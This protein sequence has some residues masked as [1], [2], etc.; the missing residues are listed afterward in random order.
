MR[1]ILNWLGRIV[2][3]LLLVAMFWYVYNAVPIIT[4]YS[5]KVACSCLFISGRTLADVK[6]TE[7]N[8][9][10]FSLANVTIN[11][12]DSSITAN[13][14]GM[15][16]T[17]AVYRSGLGCTLTHYTKK[18][19]L[20]AQ[21][22]ALA[23]PLQIDQDT[24][25]WPMG[26]RHSIDTLNANANLKMQQAASY[27]FQKNKHEYTFG[28]RALLVVKAGKIV[29]EQYAA[30]FSARTRMAGWSM[31]K[32]ITNAMVGILVKQGKLSISQANLFAGWKND[33]RAG[34]TLNNLLNATSGLAWQEVYAGPSTATNMLFNSDNAAG[35]ALLQPAEYKPGT[36]F[37]YSSGTTNLLQLLIR[38]KTASEYYRLPYQQLFYKTGMLSAVMEPDASG[39]FVGSSFCFATAR[40]WARFGLLYLHDGVVNG[41]RILPEGWVKYS[42]TPSAAAKKGQY[43]AQFWTNAGEPGNPSNR[44][45]PSVPTDCFYAEGYEGQQ[46]WII[47]SKKLVV[48]RLSLQRGTSFNENRFLKEV[49]DALP[50]D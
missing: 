49:I 35:L 18:P 13:V 16:S 19:R 41:Q 32:S 23:T 6:N 10:P 1:K 4:G 33:S 2:L 37:K 42:A 44:T 29:W 12:R 30:G 50:A 34:I 43:G 24:I 15:A 36:H 48:V 9:L 22:I 38:K 39:T 27:A 21:Q 20:E 8:G 40:D 11:A 45:Y 25:D 31:T 46:V 17:T 14:W 26:N 28:T 7:L 5:A 47:P 3:L